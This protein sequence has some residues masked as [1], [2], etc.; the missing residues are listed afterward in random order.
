[1]NVQSKGHGIFQATNGEDTAT[2]KFV[3]GAR[4]KDGHFHPKW[5]IR[6]NNGRERAIEG[7]KAEAV[8]AVRK[9]LFDPLEAP[10]SLE[11]IRAM[12]KDERS[13][14]VIHGIIAVELY[15]LVANDLEWLNDLA[16][17]SLTDTVDLQNIGY[18][19]VGGNG[20][21]VLIRVSGTI[22]ELLDRADEDTASE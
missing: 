20:S 19:V 12:I 15:D 7:G 16:T 9:L 6:L 21:T 13:E 22:D 3:R 10:M 1:M 4:G 8:E 11:E 17:L 2:A 14:N 5:F 18:H